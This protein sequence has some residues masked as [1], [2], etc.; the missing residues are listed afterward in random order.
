MSEGDYGPSTYGESF[1]DVYDDWYGEVSDVDATVGCIADL[2]GSR[3]V[4]ELGVGTGRVARPLAATG[5][6]VWGVDASPAMLAR[7]DGAPVR[8]VVGDM[9]RLPFRS[10]QSFGVVF[11]AYNTFFNLTTEADQR[12]CLDQVA[13]LIC[14]GGV[15]AIETFV[16][17]D[18]VPA[19]LGPV[20]ARAVDIDRVILSVS[21][22]D[23]TDQ[24]ITGQ[25]IE[26][27]D[28][29]PARLRPWRLR[30]LRPDQ[31]DEQAGAAGLTREYRW[32]D[33]SGS[34][35]RDD[36]DAQVTIYRRRV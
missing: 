22:H 31:L 10:N 17:A 35:F 2:A 26:L 36:S 5:V 23:A 13:A 24:L 1:A 8:A 32:S 30:Y 6:E 11:A 4:L 28:G 3:P 14:P 19:G 21:D 15:V 34:P 20:S 27:R 12:A 16:P 25:H 18:D 9:A 7:L 33:W 29:G